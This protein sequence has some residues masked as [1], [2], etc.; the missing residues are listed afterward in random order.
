MSHC[1]PNGYSLIKNDKKPEDEYFYFSIDNI[2]GLTPENKKLYFVCVIIHEAIESYLNLNK[3][4]GKVERNSY[5]DI[6]MPKVLCLSSFVS[7]PNETKMLLNELIIYVK[8]NNIT[9]PLEKII[10]SIIFGIP[11]PL[12]AYF[13]IAFNKIIPA[14]SKDIYF[15]LREF[16]QYQFNSY[17]FQSIFNFTTV[18]ILSIY[19]CLLLEIPLLFFSSNKE[20]LSNIIESFLSL[21]YPF[22]YQYP[23]ITILP[24]SNCG[25]IETEKCFIFGINRKLKFSNEKETITLSYFKE[26]NL[27]IPNKAILICDIDSKKLNSY[28]LEYDKLNCHIVNFEDLGE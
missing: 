17:I 12:K 11:R 20:L 22:E 8:N 9:I 6:Y 5:S 7:F 14:Q 13:Y 24:D 4:C 18:N 28:C 27:N 26:M 3:K 19:K 10:E 2:F 1:F 16:N 23:N 21:I 15:I 25:L